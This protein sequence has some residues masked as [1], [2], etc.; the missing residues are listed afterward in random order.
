[1]GVVKE[2]HN[3]PKSQQLLRLIVDIG[4]ERQVVAGIA[5]WYE[6]ADLVGKQVVL[7]AN[8]QPAK[9]MGI[10]SRGMVLAVQDG[11]A[12]RLIAPAEPVTPGSRVS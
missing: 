2:A 8:L 6:P 12:L 3:V 1:V 5:Q 11:K 4:E 10:E 7:V 9:L